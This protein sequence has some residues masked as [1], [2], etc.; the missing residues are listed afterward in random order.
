[1]RGTQGCCSGSAAGRRDGSALSSVRWFVL[2]LALS[3][4]VSAAPQGET[5][6]PPAETGNDPF[7]YYA[8]AG[9]HLQA[10]EESKAAASF[11]L[12]LR[13][14]LRSLAS[15]TVKTGAIEKALPLY[16]EAVE[17]APN[18]VD[19][20]MQY[21]RALFGKVK[22][23]QAKEHAQQAVRLAPDNPDAILLLGQVLF[24]LRQY[25]DA[26]VQFE[27]AFAKTSD[28]ATGYLLGKSCLLMKDQP[29]AERV[30]ATIM[31]EFGDTDVNHIF[32]GRAYSQTGY[33]KGAAAEFRRAMEINPAVRG[34]HYQLA[35]SYLREDEAAG[36][37][38]A[39]PE[40]RAELQLNPDDFSSHYML[41]YIAV[42][43]GRWDEAEKELVRATSLRPKDILA[44]VALADTFIAT[45][46]AKEAE[47]TLRRVLA[48]AGNQ[49][50]QEIARAHYLLARLLLAQPG[51][52]DEAK[53]ELAIVAEM[54][55]HSGTVLTA[56]ARAAGA[57]SIL[58]EEAEAPPE[59]V[60]ATG[61][62]PPESHAADQ[63][64]A[65]IADAY[66]NLGAIAG[67]EKDFAAAASYF[68]HAQQWNSALP[69]V[70]R[71]LGM[72]LFS[73]SQFHEAAPLLKSYLARNPDDVAARGAL[74]F[75]LS[76][77][78]DYAGVVEALRPIE[79]QM[80]ATPKL[81]FVYAA[82]LARTG[83]YEEGV[84]RLKLLGAAN[85]T[86]PEIHYELSLAY[87]HMGRA[88]DAIQEMKLYQQLKK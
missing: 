39:I 23:L 41:G 85:R 30:F 1:M 57:G 22:F 44:L 5:P 20:R 34:A 38:Q 84:R 40:F 63:L 26:R 24:Q 71:N 2:L 18:D 61:P 51:R 54:Q 74:G 65:T 69:G 72:A 68:R 17:I 37:E 15:A 56:D 33:A 58:R 81:A 42:Q 43:Q 62:P 28:F 79:D 50:G 49:T 29:A 64:R 14:V 86:S 25:A 66:N 73:S 31:R 88:E 10:G 55:K 47:A 76:R 80:S 4:V 3:S 78:E 82:A 12:F 67:D 6:A 46:R 21:A 83:A 48:E 9:R 59:R 32:V 13:E 75:S 77:I 36:Y 7:A 16:E 60:A 87:Q 11:R 27:A 35:L 19:L 70:D 45:K 52:Q 8:A 53:R